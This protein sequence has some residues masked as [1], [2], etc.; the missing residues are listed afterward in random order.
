MKTL[1]SY[2]QKHPIHILLLAIPVSVIS[3]IFNWRAIWIFGFSAIAVIP[4][5]SLI[6]ESTEALAA[7]TGP[8]IGGLLNAT[9]GNAAELI[10]T[11]MA[12][13]Q[14]LLELV[15]ASITGS[16]IGNLLLVMGLSMLLGGLKNGIQRFDRQQSSNHAVML[17]VVII[18]L[19]IPSFFSHSIGVE[20]SWGVELLSLG[21]AGVMI[22]LYM[23]G[24]IYTLRVAKSPIAV[25]AVQLESEVS[26]LWKPS[27]AISILALSTLGVVFMSEFL[28][29][30]VE[31][32]I[33]S[34]GV[35]EFFLGVILIPL[36]GNIAEH[37]VSVTVAVRNN[38]DLSLEIA[39]SSSLQIALFVAPL[40]VFISLL[41]G[42]PLTLIFNRFELLALG[43]GVVI[44]AMVAF[45][46]ESNWLEG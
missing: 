19:I 21:V 7:Y 31:E 37:L 1:I 18:A 10:I 2:L 41:I 20:G 45:D 16:I 36:I 4:L 32:V 35:S 38:M 33:V 34:F 30:S 3:E 6:G 46:G 40:L 29:G 39:V 12:I 42:N 25:A 23:I 11:I 9:L 14:G 43:G 44:A 5:A 24:L 28:V 22:A 17:V 26:R 27:R 15:K 8:K 13:R